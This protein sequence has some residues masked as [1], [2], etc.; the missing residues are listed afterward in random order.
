[1]SRYPINRRA[2]I[3][4]MPGICHWAENGPGGLL[5]CSLDD[6]LT[7]DGE[8]RHD[9]WHPALVQLGERLVGTSTTATATTATATATTATTPT[10]ERP[11][12]EPANRP[13][14]YRT[15]DRRSI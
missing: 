2:T 6:E 10:A 5:D 15:G 8:P 11:T 9:L 7:V 12:T 1:M 3:A 4:G 13:P 14:I